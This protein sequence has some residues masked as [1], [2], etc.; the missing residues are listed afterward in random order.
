MQR[1]KSMTDQEF[2]QLTRTLM[3]DEAYKYVNAK[4]KVERDAIAS[5]WK[6]KYS[7]TFADELRRLMKKPAEARKVAY[8][9]IEDFKKPRQ[10]E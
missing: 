4:N 8:W 1:R 2:L 9:K 7:E 5:T 10:K 3:R 6:H